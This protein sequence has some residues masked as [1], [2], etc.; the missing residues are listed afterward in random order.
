MRL[1]ACQYDG[2]NLAAVQQIG[3]GAFH[4]SDTNWRVSFE[5]RPVAGDRAARDVTARFTLAKGAAHSA[6]VAVAFDFSDWRAD[7]YV[8]V[9]AA[10]YNGNRNRIVPGHYADPMPASDL[11]DKNLALSTREL[12]GLSVTP[13]AP[14]RFELLANNASTPCLAFLSRRTGKAFILL[15]EQGIQV[16]D[17][18]LDTGLAVE[19]SVDRKSASLVVSAPEVRERKPEFDGFSP[20]P[21]RG[22][23][24][25][26]GDSYTIRLRL[27]CFNAGSM[28]G[29]FNKYSAVRKSLTGENHPRNIYP[30]SEVE[31]LETERI[32]Q[33]FFRKGSFAYY[34]PE[35]ATWMVPGWIGGLINTYPMLAIGDAEHIDKVASTFDFTLGKGQG[36]SGYFHGAIDE[37]GVCF[38]RDAFPDA[39][40]VLARKNGDVLY[41]M[42][43]QFLLLKSQGAAHA[44]KPEWEKSMRRLADAFVGTW[45]RDGQWGNY[46]NVETGDVAVY[47]STSA[48]QAIGGLALASGYFENPRYLEVAEKAAAFYYQRDFLGLGATTGACAD[49]LQNADSESAMAF[50]SSLTALY[51]VTGDRGWIEEARDLL[52]LASSWVV[53]YDYRLPKDTDFAKLGA[54]LAGAIFA[55]TQNKHGAPGHCTSACDPLLKVYR[56]TGDDRYA[57]LLRDIFHAYT[58]GIQPDGGI[59]ERLTYCDA[60]SRGVLVRGSN[61][62]CE[63]DGALMALELPSIYV[64]TD[65]DKFYVFDSI[66]AKVLRRGPG[67]KVTLQITNPT[68]FHADVAVF[69]ETAS[70]ARKPYGYCAFLKWPKFEVEPGQT[71]VVEVSPTSLSGS[72]Y[73]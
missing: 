46:L 71:V 16:G 23:D 13:G 62:W 37:N 59:T 17:S 14:S 31:R 64:Q 63:T 52:N 61:G 18:I 68:R 27:F 60:D 39:N 48:A 30:M 25:R 67:G 72:A 38:S 41:W 35:N 53:S 50:A 42:I 28:R 43:K 26:A 20:S 51:E 44:I 70:Q 7:N 15:A 58:E 32:A 9:P 6:G 19:E 49:I 56:A 2:P 66:S 29:L 21:D 11:Y 24:W 47:N 36:K 40:I 22:I 1:L 55:S 73:R 3:D 34:T 69:A 65:S 45:E 10:V 8:L 5:C 12:P 33:R 4:A 54:H 57:E